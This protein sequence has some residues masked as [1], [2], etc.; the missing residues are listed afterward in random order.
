MTAAKKKKKKKKLV[1]VHCTEIKVHPRHGGGN[2]SA[3]VTGANAKEARPM[4]AAVI[5]L[6]Q[7]Y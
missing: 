2:M 1:A 3:V 6:E 4:C 7:R 5:S